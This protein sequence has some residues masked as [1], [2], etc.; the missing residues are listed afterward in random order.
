MIDPG[1]QPAVT[2]ARRQARRPDDA[3][4]VR[5]LLRLAD[6]RQGRRP[7]RGRA[8]R[9]PRR[10]PRSAPARRRSCRWSSA[11]LEGRPSTSRAVAGKYAYALMPTIPPGATALPRGRQ[12]ARPASCPATTWS[13]PS[14]PRTRTWPSPW[15]R[16]SPAPSTQ[17]AVLQDLRRPADQR[18]GGGQ[19]L[20]AR[21]GARRD[22]RRVGQVRRHPVHR[23]LGPHP[24]GAGQRGG[25]VDPGPG[26]GQGGRRR[27]DGPDRRPPRRRPRRP[28]DKGK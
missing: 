3:E 25:P 27:P 1:R 18:R 20:Q 14:T 2:T 17:D 6:Q 22:H 23:R 16:C 21:P 4:G 5:D 24:A 12:A 11:T 19:T 26:R 9:T 10:S 7:G 8:G 13:W 15:S 28:L